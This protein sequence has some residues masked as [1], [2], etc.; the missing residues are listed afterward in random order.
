MVGEMACRFTWL[1]GLLFDEYRKRQTA[2]GFTWGTE[3]PRLSTVVLHH[4]PQQQ[5]E[6]NAQHR[7]NQAANGQR[8]WG[9][10]TG[11]QPS[12][13]LDA[14]GRELCLQWNRG[15][16]S[17]G[18]RCNLEHHAPPVGKGIPP[19][20]TWPVASARQQQRRHSRP[21]STS[22]SAQQQR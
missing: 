6:H 21:R 14:S 4:Q 9:R 17:Y 3:M 10:G 5:Q 16:C 13:P 20:N 2:E 22:G 1:S 18:D 11:G 7:T 19:K 15:V 12:R 8:G